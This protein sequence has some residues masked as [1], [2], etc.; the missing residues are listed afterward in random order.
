MTTTAFALR[1]RICEHEEA[2]GPA[3]DCPRCDGPTDVA[4]DLEALAGLV[5]RERVAG[6]PQSL[7]RYRD[8]LPAELGDTASGQAVGWTP[9][10]RAERL[11]GALDLDVLVKAETANPTGSYK[12]RTGALAGAAAAALGLETLF[13]V[14]NGNLGAAVAAEAAGRGLEAIVLAP[15]G[16]IGADR[17][18]S[19]GAQVIAVDG[20]YEDCVELERA[21][22]PLFPWGFLGGNLSPYAAEGA[23]TISFEIAEQL[24]W[25]LPSA[26]VCAVWSG[27]LLAKIA[28][29]FHELCAV[30]LV[31]GGTPRLY[32]AQTTASAPVAAAYAED[33]AH[34]AAGDAS[35]ADLAIG[36]ARASGGEIVT[37]DDDEIAGYTELLVETTGVPADC[38]GGV[39]LGT[40][41]EGVRSGRI[42]RGERVVLV[43]SGTI[44]TAGQ[45]R[46]DSTPT[47]RP[48]LGR[49]LAELGA[50]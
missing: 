38:A 8:L 49:L 50:S 1:C 11:S 18:G 46:A 27:A 21:L 31:D 20:S 26:V 42:R 47:I 3:T 48:D 36:A 24:G 14:S 43:V 10:V 7:W 15:E 4:Y 33:R 29:G 37:L 40:L 28:Q 6:G 44:E 39:A 32:G 30:G 25:E 12:D 34:S 23:K 22:A 5:S 16:G 19:V 17:P 45:A 13:C 35:Y 9:L 2:P 41:V